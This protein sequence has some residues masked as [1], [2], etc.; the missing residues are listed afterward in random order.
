MNIN[1][2]RLLQTAAAAL[3]GSQARQLRAGNPGFPMSSLDAHLKMR[4]DLRGDRTYWYYWGTVFGNEH[5]Q[6]TQPMLGVEGISFSVLDKLPEGRF[7]YSLTEAGYY[8]DLATQSITDEV[9]NPFTGEK[10]RPVNYLSSQRNF[11]SPDLSVAPDLEKPPPGFDFRGEITPVRVFRDSVWSA[12]D[13]F[14]RWPRAKKVAGSDAPEIRVQ[15]SL[16]TFTANRQELLDPDVGFVS[17]QLNYQTLGTWREWMGMGR[18]PGMISWRM[19]GTKCTVG[20]LPG[21]LAERIAKD[22]QGFFDG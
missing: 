14:V 19:V 9:V 5:G 21:R 7:R 10:Y 8:L 20:E 13:L 18:R 3:A 16:A 15:T 17:C 12:E 22:H 1:R 4:C 2:R 6:S 11:F